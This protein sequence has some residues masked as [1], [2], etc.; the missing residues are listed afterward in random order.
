VGR[1]Y[2][3]ELTTGSL[4]GSVCAAAPRPCSLGTAATVAAAA[5]LAALAAS[6]AQ[7]RCAFL[8]AQLALLGPLSRGAD[9]PACT[10][11]LEAA[12]LTSQISTSTLIV[13]SR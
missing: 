10:Q 13:C 5:A 9:L 12:L 1:Q 11:R 2:P 7:A 4:T 3:V 6:K 8:G